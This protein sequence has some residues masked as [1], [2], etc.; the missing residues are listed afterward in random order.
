LRNPLLGQPV[1]SHAWITTIVIGVGG[2]LLGL[3]VIG[4]YQRRMI[5]WM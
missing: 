5:F 3:P 4:R 1:S 2:V